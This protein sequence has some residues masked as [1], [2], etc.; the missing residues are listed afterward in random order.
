MAPHASCTWMNLVKPQRNLVHTVHSHNHGFPSREA[1][2]WWRQHV[3]DDVTQ[4]SAD[5][6]WQ[7]VLDDTRSRWRQNRGEHDTEGVDVRVDVNIIKR[8]LK[9]H[10]VA[11]DNKNIMTNDTGKLYD[12]EKTPYVVKATFYFHTKSRELNWCCDGTSLKRHNVYKWFGKY[13]LTKW[14]HDAGHSPLSTNISL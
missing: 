12:Q 2:I 11:F 6:T 9:T 8:Y 7:L 1:L 5:V 10:T 13:T 3:A 14:R 4:P